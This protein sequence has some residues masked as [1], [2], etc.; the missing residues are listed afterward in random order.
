MCL[1]SVFLYSIGTAQEFTDLS[2]LL[3]LR[4][5]V[6]M[7]LFL[8]VGSIYGLALNFW[9]VFRYHKFRYLIGAGGY[10]LLGVFG[11]AVAV[12]GLF[13]IIVAGGNTP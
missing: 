7:G 5:A 10:M 8:G 3:L 2:M 12:L 13:I 6:L 1:L 11:A 4:I 9:L